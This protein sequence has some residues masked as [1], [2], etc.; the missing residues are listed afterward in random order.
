MTLQTMIQD[1]L[2]VFRASH[3]PPCLSLYMTTHRGRA[4]SQQDA[5][6]YKHL[7]KELE[8]S[9]LRRHSAREAAALVE[10]FRALA[11]DG[12]FWSRSWEGLAVLGATG[13]FR[14]I[15]LHQA[16]PDLAV[17][18]DSFHIKPLLRAR[19]AGYRYQVLSLTR[20]EVKLFEGD[21]GNLDEVE[22]AAGVPRTMAEALGTEHTEPHQTVASYGGTAL[23]SNMRHGHGSKRDE[24]EIDD[25]RFFR[26]VDKAIGE[27]HSRP[28]GLPLI[29]AALTQH[30]STFRKVSHNPFLL[31]T[32]IEV[33]PSALT[34]EQLRERAWTV[35]EPELRARMSA[36]AEGFEAAKAKG[37]G[38]DNLTKVAHAAAE[39]RVESLM[40]EL[41]R[42]IPG[43][44]NQ[45]T[46]VVTLSRLED[47][48]VDDLLDDLAELVL[49]R[50]GRVMVAR[51]SDMPTATGLAAT[52]RY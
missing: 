39:S 15:R 27:H 11:E 5:T 10:P 26:A 6:R 46:G 50:G 49:S 28:S 24:V 52:F 33:D 29:L 7:V 18:A 20:G 19:Q 47:P 12:G 41:E 36:W 43:R 22:L 32:G 51:A 35:V 2:A 16:V 3:A 8:E 21:G 17:A 45:E 1:E 30:H 23:G 42:R 25:E 40:V 14:T 44:L 38:S 4:E 37:L 48:Q 34:S 31:E 9:L 13:L